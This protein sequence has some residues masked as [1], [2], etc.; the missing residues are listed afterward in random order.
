M[1]SNKHYTLTTTILVGSFPENHPQAD[2]DDL[3]RERE[4]DS[5]DEL[6]SYLSDRYADGSVY[7]P[8]D[9]KDMFRSDPHRMGDF[10]ALDGVYVM[11]GATEL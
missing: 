4:F 7:S 1:T 11:C 9:I 2:I 3:T 5:E 8:S 6:L 10:E